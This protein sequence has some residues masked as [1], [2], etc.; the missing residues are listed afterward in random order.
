MPDLP[1]IPVGFA[2]KLGVIVSALFGVAT[3]VTAIMNGDHTEETIAALAAAVLT[4]YKVLDGRY[5]QAT[6]QVTTAIPTDVVVTNVN[7]A[8]AVPSEADLANDFQGEAPD[9]PGTLKPGADF[10]KG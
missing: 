4:L 7:G 10:T 1:D 3:I 9:L 8:E 5:N 6:A 2:T